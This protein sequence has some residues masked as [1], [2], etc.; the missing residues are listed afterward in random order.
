MSGLG[1][2]DI[3]GFGFDPTPRGAGG[4]VMPCL[5]CLGCLDLRCMSDA[6]HEVH[7]WYRLEQ[8]GRLAK[9]LLDLTLCH[10]ASKG[11]WSLVLVWLVMRNHLGSEFVS[12]FCCGSMLLGI[13][14]IVGCWW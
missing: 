14:R 2:F 9:G 11:G 10:R 4:G 12:C 5:G 3:G 13:G 8:H 7:Y 6:H 1:S